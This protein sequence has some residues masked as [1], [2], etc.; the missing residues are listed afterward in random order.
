MLHMCVQLLSVR[1]L[2]KWQLADNMHMLLQAEVYCLEDLSP[3]SHPMLKALGGSCPNCDEYDTM[4][5]LILGMLWP[6]VDLRSTVGDALAS[7]FFA[8]V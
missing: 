4:R 1:R 3:S 7:H 8:D 6:D 5:D 2:P